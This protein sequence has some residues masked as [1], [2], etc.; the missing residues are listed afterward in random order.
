MTSNNKHNQRGG[1]GRPG[2]AAG[3]VRPVRVRS[4][5]LDEIQEDK[6]TLAF[7]LIARDLVD[8]RTEPVS[9][10]T[11]LRSESDAESEASA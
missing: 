6:L 1:G 2:S 11:P 9:D 7:Y 8:D 3:G 10:D 5:R 4:K